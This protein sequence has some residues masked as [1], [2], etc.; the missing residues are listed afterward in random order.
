MTASWLA[1]LTEQ[2][3]YSACPDLQAIPGHQI[4]ALDDAINLVRDAAAT[5][6]RRSAM[7]RNMFP[8]PDPDAFNELAAQYRYEVKD[9]TAARVRQIDA[10]KASYWAAVKTE[11]AIL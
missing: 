11:L 9:Y 6:M 1:A 3:L 7:P 8:T 10:A 5:T 4:T 2:D